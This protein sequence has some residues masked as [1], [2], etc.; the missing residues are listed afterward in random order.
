MPRGR[1]WAAHPLVNIQLAYQ[2]SWAHSDFHCRN[3]LVSCTQQ[4]KAASD[5][6]CSSGTHKNIPALPNVL[7]F[8]SVS[9]ALSFGQEQVMEPFLTL[10]CRL[11]LGIWKS[12]CLYLLIW[13]SIFPLILIDCSVV[14]SVFRFESI[15]SLCFHPFSIFYVEWCIQI[16]FEF[17]VMSYIWHLESMS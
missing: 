13:G 8:H 7:H 3:L 4:M 10:K 6:S 15:Y 14:D 16:Y 11:L 1:A 2:V 5:G 12:W 17:N 9:K